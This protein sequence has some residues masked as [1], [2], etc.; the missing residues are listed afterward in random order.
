L[1]ILLLLVAAAVLGLGPVLVAAVLVDIE[2]HRVLLLQRE[3]Q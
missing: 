1:N 2:Q 3:R